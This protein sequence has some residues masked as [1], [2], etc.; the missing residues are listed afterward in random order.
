[1]TNKRTPYL[2]SSIYLTRDCPMKCDYC[3]IRDSNLT[4][5]LLQVEQWKRAFDILKDDLDCQFNLL[6]GNEPL[7]LGDDLI[8][9][10]KYLNE[11]DI[12]YAMYTTCPEPLFTRYKDKLIDAGV[13]SV[14]FGFDQLSGEGIDS[15]AIKSLRGLRG[16]KELKTKGLKD[17]QGTITMSNKNI[18]EV[19][20]L[21]KTLTGEGIWSVVNAIHWNKDGK[22]DFFPTADEMKDYLITDRAKFES[23]IKSIQAGVERGEYKMQNHSEH[24][25]LLLKYGMDMSWHCTMPAIISIDA[26]GSL[27]LCAYRSSPETNEYTIFDMKDPIKRENYW[28]VWQ[29]ESAKCPGCCWSYFMMAEHHI[30]K[31]DAEFGVK[32]FQDHASRHYKGDK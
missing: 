3:R 23:V 8:E 2:L 31:D 9:L 26:D 18:D 10:I 17:T 7:L 19:E 24:F 4:K 1:M 29:T 16:I 12:S 25:D 11:R 15:V 6:L 20:E 21:V 5:P 14:A 32:L 22:Y 28:D 30:L 13:K 27:R